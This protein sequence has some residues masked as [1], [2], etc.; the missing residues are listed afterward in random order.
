MT[1]VEET[2]RR[3]A[4][5][6]ETLCSRWVVSWLTSS[7]NSS[8]SI[9]VPASTAGQRLL[10][11]VGEPRQERVAQHEALVAAQL[12]EDLLAGPEVADDV[13]LG[14]ADG[15][16]EVAQGDGAHAAAQ[17]EVAGRFEDRLAPLLLVLRAAGPD[18]RG[19]EI[20]RHRSSPSSC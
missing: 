7:Q 9:R 16:G 10:G 13:G 15:V 12:D 8:C 2:L 17:G 5:A 20:A 14:Q 18:E 1:I 19:R 11:D 3:S 6:Y 4:A